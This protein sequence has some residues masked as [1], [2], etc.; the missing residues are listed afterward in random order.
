[1]K[2]ST[3]ARYVSALALMVAAPAATRL[4]GVDLTV[5]AMVLLIAVLFA[6]LLGP[7][8]GALAAIA[9]YF[10][11]DYYYTPP[12]HHFDF[13]HG[14]NIIA[15]VAFFV[16]AAII[17]WVVTTITRLRARE[18][19]RAREAQLRLELLNRIDA[20]EEPDQLARHTALAITQLFDVRRCIVHLGEDLGAAPDTEPGP[21][22]GLTTFAAGQVTVQIAEP[23]ERLSG[24]DRELLEA[25]VVT[26]DGSLEQ[27]RLRLESEQ[28]T[29]A[30]QLSRSRAGLVSAVSHNLRTPL[31]SIR[32]AAATLRA[33]DAQLDADD[34]GELLAI[35]ADESERLERM[36]IKTLDLSRIRAGGLELE[37]QTVDVGDLVAAAVRRIRPLGCHDAVHL[38]V[39]PELEPVT[40]DIALMEDVLLNLLE[41]ALRFSPQGASITVDAASSNDSFEIRVSDEGPGVPPDERERIF[42]EFVRGGSRSDTPGTGL[43]LAIVRAHVAVHGGS[44]WVED[45]PGGGARFVVHLPRSDPA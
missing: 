27:A 26:L 10:L 38:D 2:F 6:A 31:A 13:Q 41:N 43:G 20:G 23:R 17:G 29:I 37:P 32:A 16:A 33:P 40:L 11:Y 45:A 34:R 14:T 19:K 42:E 44:V 7:G 28:A 5:A 8:P 3:I 18:S 15:G 12:V 21:V 30:L 25:L 1:M 24:G 39:D 35:M 9:G 4:A 36:V 22:D